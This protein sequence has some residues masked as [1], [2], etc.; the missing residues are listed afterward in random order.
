M[1][2]LFVFLMTLV[3]VACGDGGGGGGTDTA[4]TPVQGDARCITSST[5]CNNTVYGNYP[6]WQ[7]YTFPYGGTNYNY[8]TY[9]QQYGACGCP[10][11]FAPA[12]NSVMG[13]GCYRIQAGFNW[14]LL[15]SFTYNTYNANAYGYAPQS[16]Y[17]FQQVSAMPNGNG[18]NCTG[19]IATSCLIDQ[20]NSCGTTGATCQSIG[21]GNLGVCVSGY[22]YGYNTGYNYNTGYYP[23]YGYGYNTGYGYPGYGYGVGAGISVGVGVGFGYRY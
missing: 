5:L 22:G 10:V 12:Y 20:A 6:G 8:Q 19:R 11:G 16:G 17:N 21:S 2:R 4:T 3:V 9:F 7:P 23:G 15:Y 13:M 18:A 1:K 14:N